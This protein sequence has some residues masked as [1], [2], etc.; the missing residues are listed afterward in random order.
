MISM[1]PV[2]LY[3]Y[4]VLA[5]GKLLDKVR[6]LSEEQYTCQFPIGLGTLGRTLTHCMISE[7]FYIQRMQQRD[8]PAYSQ[9]P[10]RDDDP[11]PFAV[12]DAAWAEQAAQTKSALAEVSDWRATIEYPSISDG[13][14]DS[15]ESRP[16]I[17]TA[18]PGDIFTQ[19]AM[20][21]VH[22]RAQAMNMLRQLGIT[23]GDIDF[24]ALMYHRREAD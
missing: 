8:I 19:L 10:I 22:H 15:Q 17:V 6:P 24:N 4:L 5:R 18:S 16:V 7:W 9:W 2:R 23:V 21:E 1:D 11:P 14:D 20:H 13:D 12:I 3:D